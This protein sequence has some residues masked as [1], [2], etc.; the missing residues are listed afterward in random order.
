MDGKAG[1]N[2]K[3]KQSWTPKRAALW[4]DKVRNAIWLNDWAIKVFFQDPRP[5]FVPD[6]TSCDAIGF[7]DLSRRLT[8]EARI[9]V[10]PSRSKGEERDVLCHEVLH[11]LF[12]DAGISDSDF[13]KSQCAHQAIYALSTAMASFYDRKPK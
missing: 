12:S 1:N 3:K 2:M 10:S 5:D 4:V 6:N 9:W 8:K 7:C 11:I 13:F